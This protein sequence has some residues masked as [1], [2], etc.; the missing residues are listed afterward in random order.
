[1]PRPKSDQ[2]REQQLN[3]AL[4][5]DEL[6]E[7]QA[8]ANA[9]GMRLVDYAR[10]ALLDRRVAAHAVGVPR[11]SML[12]RLVFEQWKRVGNNLNQIA[13]NFNAGG[14]PNPPEL[15]DALRAYIEIR[16]AIF[17][18]LGI[19]EELPVP[20]VVMAAIGCAST[21]AMWLIWLS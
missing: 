11:H 1:M 5:G 3:V 14:L 21:F 9:C 4:R 12:D 20:L 17:K 7:L 8:R 15:K 18:A 6:A 16:N 10:A 13:R 2:R 19:L